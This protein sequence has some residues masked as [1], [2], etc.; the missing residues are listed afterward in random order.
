MTDLINTGQVNNLESLRPQYEKYKSVIGNRSFE[1]WANTHIQGIKDEYSKATGKSLTTAEAINYGSQEGDINKLKDQWFQ[2][3]ITSEISGIEN[4]TNPSILEQYNKYKSV[5]GDRSFEDWSVAH[6]Q[7]IKHEYKRMTGQ[8]LS[9]GMATYYAGVEGDINI[10]KKKFASDIVTQ[11]YN[12]EFGRVVDPSGFQTYVNGVLNGSSISDITTSL[13]NSEE[14]MIEVG[15]PTAYWDKLGREPDAEGLANYIKE[16]KE[17]R[18]QRGDAGLNQLRSIFENSQEYADNGGRLGEEV[19]DM[20]NAIEFPEE[21]PEMPEWNDEM[22]R[23]AEAYAEAYYG[24]YFAQ[25]LTELRQ[26]YD[27]ARERTTE[28]YQSALDSITADLNDYVSKT[29]EQRARIEEDFTKEQFR[30][31]EDLGLTKDKIAEDRIRNLEDYGFKTDAILMRYNKLIPEV[32]EKWANAGM[33]FSGKRV[34]EELY[35][36]QQK[37]MEKLQANRS[38]ERALADLDRSEQL[39]ELEAARRAEDLGTARGRSI[40]D[41]ERGRETYERK[42]RESAEGL[43]TTRRRAFENIAYDQPI[44]ERGLEEQRQEY[45]RSGTEGV[46]SR[47]AEWERKAEQDWWDMYGDPYNYQMKSY[48]TQTGYK[49]PIYKELGYL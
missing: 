10:L 9:D 20:V 6:Q 5:L 21:Y 16:F 3:K 12:E 22:Q 2:E 32:I 24:P 4:V 14:W 49:R 11:V 19:R 18:I 27:M 34:Q 15:I 48:Q 46:E 40:Y 37:E 35:Y 17:G 29:D 13:R 43:E 36:K 28:D 25:L 44:K 45:M 42:Y 38:Y 7:G 33:T 47:R 41:I 26:T 30:I 31:G 39:Y 8:T 23:E 1:D